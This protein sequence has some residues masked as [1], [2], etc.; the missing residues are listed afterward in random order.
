MDCI[1][2]YSSILAIANISLSQVTNYYL[3]MAIIIKQHNYQRLELSDFE[4]PFSDSLSKSVNFGL[5]K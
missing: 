2:L 3:N 4:S 1:N 5:S